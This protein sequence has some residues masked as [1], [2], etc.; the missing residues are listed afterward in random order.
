MK[1]YL[2]LLL[3]CPLLLFAGEPSDKGGFFRRSPYGQSLLADVHPN[4][5]RF[6][7]ASITNHQEWDWGQTGK[8]LRI[9][10]FCVMGVNLP[11][12]TSRLNERLS[13]SVALPMSTTIWLD[14][15]EPVTAP[16]VNTDY[17]IALPVFT[18][19]R[20]FDR[21]FVKNL[22][23]DIALYKHEST[24]LGDEMSLQRVENQL[25]LYRVN[26][27]NH[28]S[29]LVFSINEADRDDV[30]WHTFKASL[31]FLWNARR[32]W[33]F[34]DATDG[35]AS[36]AHPKYSPWEAYL[37]YQYQ[38]PKRHSMQWV[39]SA[40]IRNR[41]L[42]GYPEFTWS[43]DGVSYMLQEE[44]RIFTYNLFCGVRFCGKRD[45]MFSR[46]SVGMRLY[47]GN[48]PYGQFRNHKNFNHIGVCVAFE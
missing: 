2:L 4:F 39:V 26:V 8:S 29:E 12:W 20:H 32:G 40:E 22:S 18:L 11:I 1:K 23:V 44:R 37:Q 46:M 30:G 6:D 45:G 35:D 47:H 48:N 14:L 43:E 19:T 41:A 15:F 10:T 24:H 7:V 31:L 9:N 38:S 17:R 25:P 13:L 5:V 33:Y 36:L 27:S 28:Y 3:L 21:G 34:I 16:V 42:Y